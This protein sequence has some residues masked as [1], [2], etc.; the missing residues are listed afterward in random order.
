MYKNFILTESEK[1]QILNMHK[2]HGYKKPLNEGM[3]MIW[4]TKIKI[5]SP[6]ELTDQ[7]K[8]EMTNKFQNSYN[9][10]IAVEF[11]PNEWYDYNGRIED[12]QAY[13]EHINNDVYGQFRKSPNAASFEK[14]V[15]QS[16]RDPNLEEPYDSKFTSYDDYQDKS[17][18]ELAARLKDFN[19][20]RENGELDEQETQINEYSDKFMGNIVDKF[21]QEAGQEV[22]S[23]IKRFKEISKN[24]EN[25]DITTYSW[26]DLKSV[27]DS[28]LNKGERG[29][30]KNMKK[31]VDQDVDMMYGNIPDSTK[32]LHKDRMMGD[33][34]DRMKNSHETW[35]NRL[36]SK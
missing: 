30:E 1:E 12:I 15:R 29:W 2:S 7:E 17:R 27:V 33:E 19:T 8:V 3:G 14:E 6:K 31:Q 26:N 32:K 13:E 36:N 22:E 34:M 35:R 24:L 5:D 23:Y 16:R 20:R 21:K 11:G 4:L 28:Y 25:K 10:R 18:K 9:G